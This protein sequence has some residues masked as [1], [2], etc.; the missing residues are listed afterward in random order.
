MGPVMEG[1]DKKMVVF[2]I[3]GGTYHIMRPLMEKGCLPNLAALAA[4]G[5]KSE[6][7]STTPF[8]TPTA[9]TSFMTGVNPGKHG[10]FDFTSDSHRTY[11]NG[12]LVNSG[13]IKVKTLWDLLSKHGK[14]MNIITVPFTYPPTPL[15]GTML[16]LGNVSEGRFRSYPPA[17]AQ[18]IL[19]HI[20]GYEQRYLKVIREPNGPPSEELLDEYIELC[21]YQ[22]EKSKQ[23]AMYLLRTHPWDFLMM[24]FV[25]TDRF[26]HYFWRYMDPGHPAYDPLHGQ[27]RGNLIADSYR[28][29]DEAIGEI[30]KLVPKEAHVMVMSDHG[31]GPL[32][33][34]FH[35]NRWLKEQ[36]FLYLRRKKAKW[37]VSTP[38]LEKYLDKAGLLKIAKKLPGGIRNLRIPVIAKKSIPL[39]EAIDWTKTKAYATRWGININLRTREPFGIVEPGQ[40]YE[41][42]VETIIKRIRKINDPKT[43]ISLFDLVL[44]K[45]DIYHGQYLE[46]AHDILISSDNTVLRK[47]PGGHAT[48]RKITSSDLGNGDHRREGILMLNGPLIDS[49]GKPD[50]PQLEDLSPTILYLMGLPVPDY[51]DGR[52]LT[53]CIKRDVLERHPVV[54]VSSVSMH[55]EE[56]A[57]GDR[58]ISREDDM[59]TRQQLKN[60][61]YIE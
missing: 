53:S 28:K 10:L 43:G 25:I 48:L 18:E 7:S 37:V 26:Q 20:G 6:L 33:Y 35:T 50:N 58:E 21:N 22:L 45:E 46:E 4:N 32:H 57:S 39:V 24:V 29:T 54:R 44:R 19:D 9:F 59:L 40:D 41:A 31:F 3:D 16:C 61:G 42:L 55:R 5:V 8:V 11:D 47:D 36:G 49:D 30:L 15:N 2:G 17:L 27:K 14:R 12:P 51:M 38:S 52:V 60:L 1:Q 34:V 13:N 23:A 56:T